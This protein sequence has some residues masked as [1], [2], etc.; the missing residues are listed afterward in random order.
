[1]IVTTFREI[2]PFFAKPHAE[3]L[4]AQVTNRDHSGCDGRRL[5]G[6]S[7]LSEGSDWSLELTLGPFKNS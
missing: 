4:G 1:M 6:Q 5:E 7:N 2:I 3:S